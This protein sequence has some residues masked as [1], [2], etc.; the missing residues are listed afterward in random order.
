MSNSQTEEVEPNHARGRLLRVTARDPPPPPFHHHHH[1]RGQL[2]ILAG[3]TAGLRVDMLPD[4]GGR[5]R[6]T[7][8]Q[9]WHRSVRAL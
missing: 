2:G 5:P 1:H 9:A 7:A 8:R 6:R 3:S 4:G